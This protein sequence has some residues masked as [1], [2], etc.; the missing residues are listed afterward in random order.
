MS[1]LHL[2]IAMARIPKKVKPARRSS[3]I[4]HQNLN[5]FDIEAIRGLPI[6]CENSISL[7]TNERPQPHSPTATVGR[8]ANSRTVSYS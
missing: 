3:P 5:C 6:P 8:P 7:P 4:D 2:F 1:A